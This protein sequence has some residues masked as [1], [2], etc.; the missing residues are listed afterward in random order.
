ME[1][2]RY[3]CHPLYTPERLLLPF[4][5]RVG[6]VHR[7]N[8]LPCHSLP[9]VLLVG[10]D[11]V[12]WGLGGLLPSPPVSPQEAVW[13]QVHTYH[14]YP[15]SQ[16]PPQRLQY[17]GLDSSRACRLT[18]RIEIF[19]WA[20]VVRSG[21]IKPPVSSCSERCT[22]AVSVSMVSSLPCEGLVNSMILYVV[23]FWCKISGS[24]ANR[25]WDIG[26]STMWSKSGICVSYGRPFI[27]ILY[28]LYYFSFL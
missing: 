3:V 28:L 11:L 8:W 14:L 12:G 25:F 4:I 16:P 24:L 9:Q 2:H 7:P 20:F 6:R 19:L 22:D 26:F 13:V 23:C 1:W 17:D 15:P 18:S 5:P 27:M 10:Q 21:W